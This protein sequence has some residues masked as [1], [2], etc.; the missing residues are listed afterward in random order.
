MVCFIILRCFHWLRSRYCASWIIWKQSK[1]TKFFQFEFLFFRLLQFF[2]YLYK[3]IKWT[4]SIFSEFTLKFQ[5]LP[6]KAQ[7]KIFWLFIWGYLANL[8]EK[9]KNKK[10]KYITTIKS[11]NHFCL[12]YEFKSDLT[13]Y[14]YNHN[15]FSCILKL[16]NI[17]L[18]IDWASF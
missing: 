15:N 9:N 7:F 11:Q 5:A 8:V 3:F 1:K 6:S 4:I 10:W 17:F 18:L 2:K 16:Y 14:F 13:R 12:I